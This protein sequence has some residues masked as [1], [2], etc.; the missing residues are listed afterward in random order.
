MSS[1]S[2]HHIEHSESTDTCQC[3]HCHLPIEGKPPYTAVVNE[4][5]QP[6]CCPGCKMVTEAIIAGGLDNYYQHRTDSA[7]QAN[8]ISNKLREELLL[9]DRDDIQKDFVIERSSSDETPDET[10]EKQASLLIEGITCAACV[11][12]LEN[13][14]GLIEGV[15]RVSVN[16]STHEAQVSWNP[17]KI[18]LSTLL[19]AIHEIGYKAYPWRED[20]Q[21][22]LLK[23]ENRTFIRRLVIAGIG[24]MQVMMYA[25]ALYSGAISNDMTDPYRDFIRYVSALVATPVIFYAAAPFFKAALRDLK[26]KNLSMDVPVSIAI[27]GA[28]LASLW[29]TVT[30]SGEVYFD[31]VSMFTF[32]L[33]TGRYL[34]LRAR[35]A[36]SRAARALR[37]S[38]PSS[39]LKKEGNDYV[40]IPLKDLKT[41]D[42]VRVLPGDSIPAD[43]LIIE[44]KSSVDESMLTGEYLPISR[45]INEAV[46]GG[47]L[48]VD[49]A[50]EV[51]ITHVGDETQMSAILQLLKHAQQDK[52][53]IAKLADRVASWFV[54]AVLITAIAVFWYWSG[55]E[56]QHAFWIALSVLV[57][58]CPCALSLATPT[59]LTAATGY[60]HKLGFLVTRGHVL[61]GLGKVNHIVFDKTG[62]L[63]QGKL[64]LEEVRAVNGCN[65][66]EQELTAI[67]S[68]LESH[69]EHPIAK[70]FI[71]P[72]SVITAPLVAESPVSHTGQGLEATIDGDNYRIGRPDFCS[73]DNTPSTPDTPGQ[74]LLMSR[75][76][77]ALCWFRISDSLRA[78]AAD[79]IHKL[80]SYGHKVT[81]LSG[82]QNSVVSSVAS[83]LNIDSW[84]AEI[85]PEGKLDY[86]RQLQEQGDHVLMIGDG[87]NDVPVL[88]GANV[89]L[90]MGNASD[91]AKTTADAVLLSDDLNRLVDAF[92]L[93][94]KTRNVIRQNLG[95][96]LA[97][98]LTALPLAAAAL[99]APWMAAIG[100]S[101]SSLVVVGNAMRLNGKQ[102]D[103]KQA[104]SKAHTTQ[105]KAVEA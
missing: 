28:Y 61:E 66:S 79:V 82:D 68:A 22:A 11:W 93:M 95:W 36:T 12:L 46:M 101:I 88:A 14:V 19:I 94:K 17:E 23:K 13:H 1:R 47:S 7:L 81:L 38:L 52:P 49:N 69:S 40:R 48:N 3:F 8:S 41:G 100:M 73:P 2:D 6:M 75:N 98:N 62:T 97:Y 91:L 25:V 24:A 54:G 92:E 72:T 84:Q 71:K 105:Y 9:Y 58:T 39:C 83:Q 10:L 55:S 27:G 45:S 29:A 42:R 90:A 64:Q 65:L 44:G 86:I 74:W 103:K 60:L 30:G 76:N 35:H 70:A 78:E 16:L 67:A 4:I 59:A 31:S 89:S 104:R 87:I 5:E 77:Q 50:I 53:A 80:K 102:A 43:G 26:V 37:N 56:P 51:E 21:E 32:F 63:T 18:P 15:S 33:L 20:R 34:E 96:S 85:S 99:I 57:V